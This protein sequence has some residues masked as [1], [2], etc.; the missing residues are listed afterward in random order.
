MKETSKP[1]ETT[2]TT[3]DPFVFQLRAS[4]I[5]ALAGRNVHRTS[6]NA[7][8][9]LAMAVLPPG[10]FSQ[11]DQDD[12]LKNMIEVIEYKIRDGKHYKAAVRETELTESIC[13]FAE[14]ESIDI[15]DRMCHANV[16]YHE[17]QKLRKSLKSV[18]LKDRGVVM[19]MTTLRRLPSLGILW[20]P[21][22]KKSRFFSRTF[23]SS[24]GGFSY[25][26]NGCVDGLEFD[27]STNTAMGLIEVKTRKEKAQ[28]PVHDLDQVMMYLVLSG[29]PMG[30]L[31]Q[32]AN[33]A[34]HLDMVMSDAEA[35][36]RW[37]CVRPLL[38]DSLGCVHRMLMESSKSPGSVVM[39]PSFGRYPRWDGTPPVGYYRGSYGR[40]RGS[41][42]RRYPSPPYRQSSW[43]PFHWGGE[44]R[45]S[46]TYTHQ[47][48]WRRGVPPPPSSV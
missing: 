34:I 19:E 7:I 12:S 41:G 14:Q 47:G 42:Y 27:E 26:I 2:T 17:R 35:R 3:T 36:V 46:S 25:T 11:G 9:E 22:E 6:S 24:D 29:L 45:R 38:E 10:S 37:E 28:Y 15:F 30:R 20:R 18:Y 31:V 5:S 39:G 32:N 44:I 1:H 40:K 4:E 13:R 48:P 23:K 43:P 8:R 16:P 21:T 33:G